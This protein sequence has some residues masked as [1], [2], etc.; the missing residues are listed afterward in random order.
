MGFIDDNDDDIFSS[1]PRSPST[2]KSIAA[3]K[4][5]SNS[6]RGSVFPSS[7]ADLRTDQVDSR[8]LSPPS[9][10]MSNYSSAKSN[11]PARF[12][13]RV[14]TMINVNS[15]RKEDSTVPER[16]SDFRSM[17][18]KSSAPVRKAP[19]V[20]PPPPSSKSSPAPSVVSASDRPTSANRASP[21]STTPRYS[22]SPVEKLSSSEVVVRMRPKRSSAT[23]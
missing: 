19:S 3:N 2:L 17:A 11:E 22:Q 21:S 23:M 10:R 14:T 20:W 8:S 18:L 12:T 6:H 16:K 15:P 1:L 7:R 4:T 9:D 13:S 5:D